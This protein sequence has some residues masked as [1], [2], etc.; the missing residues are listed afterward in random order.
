ME[1]PELPEY[2]RTLAQSLGGNVSFEHVCKTGKKV[3]RYYSK[4]LSIVVPS[5]SEVVEIA[6]WD[7]GKELWR[8]KVGGRKK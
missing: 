4:S 5:G 7:S 3:E 1:L 2:V 6:A 8:A